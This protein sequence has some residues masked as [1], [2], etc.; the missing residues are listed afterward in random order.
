MCVC[1]IFTLYYAK[2]K[3]TYCHFKSQFVL[4]F[5]LIAFN[6][7]WNLK[8]FN[9]FVKILRSFERKFSVQIPTPAH[10]VDSNTIRTK[11]SIPLYY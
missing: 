10:A 4:L 1:A 8:Y 9:L 6:K 11:T 2:Y 7:Y 3:K 5:Y